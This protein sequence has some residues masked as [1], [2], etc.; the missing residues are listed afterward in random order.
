MPAGP[1]SRY[2]GLPV[3]LARDAAGAAHAT[4][5][6]RR[7]PVPDPQAT[8]YFHTIVAGETIEALAASYLGSSASWWMI[9]DA[10][11]TAFPAVLQPGTTI[12][13]PTE[14]APGRVRRT[15]SF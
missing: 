6:A 15:R 14:A 3:G 7:T 8:P 4:I 9:A 12:V 1:R 5:P 11:P 2:R 13:V 10:N